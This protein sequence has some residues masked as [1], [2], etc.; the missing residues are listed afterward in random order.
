M[1]LVIAS[2]PSRAAESW[3][4][5]GYT[6]AEYLIPGLGYGLMGDFDKMLIFGGLRW[7]ASAKYYSYSQSP[8]YQEDIED[9]YKET[10]LEDDKTRTD[11]YFSKETY[12]ICFLANFSGVIP[13]YLHVPIFFVQ[14]LQLV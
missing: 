14:Y 11:I 2:N 3:A 9:I 7:G 1:L 8:S 5:A 13:P 4:C 12:S 6:L 10:E